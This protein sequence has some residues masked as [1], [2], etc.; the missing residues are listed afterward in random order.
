MATP[1]V[2][3]GKLR[4]NPEGFLRSYYLQ[5]ERAMNVNGI[6]QYLLGATGTVLMGGQIQFDRTPRPGRILGG[7][8]THNSKNFRF[9]R[10]AGAVVG[11]S[12][13]TLV[14]HVDVQQANAIN[15]GQIAPVPVSRAGPDIMVTT[16]LNGCSFVCEAVGP[17]VLMAH[18][19][20]TGTSSPALEA[21][22]HATGALVGGGPPGTL[23]VFGGHQYNAYEDATVIG[24]RHGQNW[25]LFAQVHP[26]GTR[27]ISRVVEFFVG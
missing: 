9:T 27:N 25:H 2:A 8:H 26:R 11:G 17:N 15:V 4:N 1:A 20:P 22:L 7:L 21:Q 6:A 24:V 18:I 23:S 12:V 5:V 14:W 10:V 16:L 13:T 19:Q 3:L